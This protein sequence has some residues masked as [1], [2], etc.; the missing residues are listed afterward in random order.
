MQDSSHDESLEDY[1]KYKVLYESSSDAIMTIEPPDWKFTSGNPAT[2]KMFNVKT[3]KEFLSLTPGDLSPKFQPDGQD[4]QEKA[5]KM[6]EEALEN[7][8][9]LFSWT[10]KRYKGEDFPATVL[11][12]KLNYNGKDIIQA[13]VRDISKEKAEKRKL[14]L[15]ADIV[16]N[17]D[18]AI[19]SKDLNGKILSWNKGAQKLYGYEAN[20]I[21]G[22]NISVLLPESRF[23]EV[24]KILKRIENG[25]KI[26][27]FETERKSKNGKIIQVSLTLS[28]IKDEDGKIQGASSIARDIT[29]QKQNEKEIQERMEE[30]EKFNKLMVGRELKMIELKEEN[31]KLKEQLQ[32]NQTIEY[33]PEEK[34]WSDKF[35]D[36][37][38]LEESVIIKLSDHYQHTIEESNISDEDKNKML[39]KLKT[40]VD[41][42]LGHKDKL[43]KLI[44]Y[45]RSK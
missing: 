20:E 29:K 23:D 22:K 31:K 33:Q 45:E 39:E 34:S 9:N 21:V 12:T 14:N 43:E 7:G 6:I 3:E 19:L 16:E 2:L 15:L 25:E 27:H 11:L 4:S 44:E 35:N 17:S 38:E 36:A 40:L 18:N 10:H 26:E 37:I 8:S 28:P 32:G 5:K 41:E 30:A 1:Q 13:T 42:S 24:K